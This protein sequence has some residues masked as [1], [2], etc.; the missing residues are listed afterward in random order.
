MKR[1]QQIA[2]NM[3]QKRDAIEE[4]FKKNRDEQGQLKALPAEDQTQVRAI[5]EELKTLNSDFASATE[6]EQI[7]L[8]NKA[9]LD[10]LAEPQYP[11]P[12][13]PG[14][15][16]KGVAE[17]GQKAGQALVEGSIPAGA[18]YIRTMHDLKQAQLRQLSVAYEE[19]ELG[20]DAKMQ[21]AISSKTYRDAFRNY[22]R[23]GKEGLAIGD[24]K[25]LQEGVDSQGGFLVPED[26]LNV[27]VQKQPTPTRV[28]GMVTR[29]QTSRDALAMPKV[30]YAADDIYT[31]G[32]RVTKTGEIP[33]S[34]TVH[35]VTEPIFG[36]IRIPV[37]TFMMSMPLTNDM[38]EDSAFPIVGWST[39]KFS[40]TVDLLY[41]NEILN[42]SGIG[43][44]AGILLNP[45]GTDQPAIV[46]SGSAAAVTPDGIFD[47][48]Y[49]LPEQYDE[50]AV[51]VF[52][53]TNTAK[54]IAK[55]KDTTNR[56][57]FGYGDQDSGIAGG[58]PKEL[59]GYSYAYS[60]FMPDIAA[61]SFPIIFGDLM[62]YYLV[63]RVGFS[64]QVLRELYAETNQIVLLGRLRFGGQVAEPWKL[65]IQKIST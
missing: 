28:A 64:V 13:A 61:N 38:I 47:L 16:E 35:R 42:G 2:A 3:K 55:L 20:L 33:S 56:Y 65:K 11:A 37:H 1:S 9:A 15:L 57:L 29:L 6:L 43:G 22:I 30:N 36:M 46:V 27:L 41:D 54:A 24:L 17:R 50:N 34:S 7:E 63:N 8:E 52:N 40:E 32:I 60:G 31:T 18:T 45:G 39:G 21:A 23:K 25:T 5:Q 26:M 62:G 49:A 12:L 59:I 44:P 19:G 14:Q 4:L 48:V 51:F 53:K 10:K 58:R